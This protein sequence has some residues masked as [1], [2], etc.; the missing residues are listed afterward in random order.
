MSAIE[1]LV[2]FRSSCEG[3]IQQTIAVLGAQ[4]AYLEKQLSENQKLVDLILIEIKAIF[5]RAIAKLQTLPEISV[6]TPN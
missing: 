6:A 2:K 3:P 5:A 4:I 1:R